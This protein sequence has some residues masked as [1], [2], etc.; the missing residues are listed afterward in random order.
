MKITMLILL[1][2]IVLTG[3]SAGQG[4]ANVVGYLPA[5][6][7]TPPSHLI[8]FWQHADHYFRMR[9]S[10]F[11]NLML[12]SLIVALFV[13]RKDWYSLPF[14]FISLSLL[15]CVTDLVII[16]TQNLPLNE[17]VQKLDP[18]EPIAIDFESIRTAALSAYYKRAVCN[19]ASFA[20]ALAGVC[21]YYG[22]IMAQLV[23]V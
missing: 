13:L 11:G 5:M 20:L 7:D 12:I 21:L 17:L 9:M 1:L 14:L 4:F 6:K 15:A 23:R 10:W 3:F 18:E 16:L 2:I 22:R 19:I 8:S